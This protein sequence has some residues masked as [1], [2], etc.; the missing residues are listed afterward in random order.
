MNIE[1]I[2]KRVMKLKALANAGV[3]GERENA[4]KLLAKLAAAYGISIDSIDG[5]EI[6]KHEVKLTQSWQR[7]LFRRLAGIMRQE[8]RKRG[9]VLRDKELELWTSRLRFDRKV[10]RCYT[11]ATKGDLLEL[12]AKFAVLEADYERQKK[13]FFLSFLIANDLLTDPDADTPMPTRKELDEYDAASLMSLGIEKSK[14]SKQ[15]ENKEAGE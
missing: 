10:I 11:Y 15:L 2:K 13:S 14:L 8:K 3:G 1:E 4:E 12:M 6:E 7:K 5:E 9:E